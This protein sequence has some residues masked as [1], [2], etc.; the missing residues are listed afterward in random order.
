M[1]DWICRHP[2]GLSQQAL[3][4]AIFSGRILYFEQLEPMAV[5]VR[6]TQALPRAAFHPHPPKSAHEVLSPDEHEARFSEARGARRA[7]QF[8]P[9]CRRVY[10]GGLSNSGVHVTL[11]R[12]RRAISLLGYNDES[13]L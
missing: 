1:S 9:R 2:V 13:L 3:F 7:K 10:D 12:D 11:S 4:E 5:A 8:R 6:E